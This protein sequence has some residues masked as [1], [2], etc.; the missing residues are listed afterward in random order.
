MNAKNN[1]SP[2][3]NK[4]F[5]ERLLS[6]LDTYSKGFDGRKLSAMGVISTAMVIS[7]SYA[8]CLIS[9]R[10]VFD[11]YGVF[12][13]L[14]LLLFGALYLS[15]I[16]GEQLENILTSKN[17]TTVIER[18]DG[19]ESYQKKDSYESNDVLKGDQTQS[20]DGGVK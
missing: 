11:M 19:S 13:V 17:S 16:D 15:I 7:I 12:L 9:G 14:A 4:G 1:N 18:H 5:I 6:S 8:Y 20:D 3:I 10:F 2:Q